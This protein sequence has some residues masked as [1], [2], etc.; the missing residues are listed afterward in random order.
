MKVPE[1]FLNFQL[2]W[3]QYSSVFLL[4]S[5]HPLSVTDIQE[6]NCHQLSEIRQAWLRFSEENSL[7]VPKSNAVMMTI[8]SAI[9][10]YLLD[11]V[12]NFQ[13]DAS[14]ETTPETKTTDSD[15]VY[16]CFGGAAISDM[17][18]L[19]YNQIKAC[20]DDQRDLLSQET[21]ILRAVNSKDKTNIPDY[22]KYRDQGYMYFPD[23]VF[24]CFLRD[25]DSAVKEIVN[26]NGL[27]QEG[28]N[29]IKVSM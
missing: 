17:L 9:Y 22:L 3:H 10:Y 26:L 19:Q 14:K 20:R 16:Y 21:S 12:E 13:S 4:S 7:P 27:Q 5:Q 8:S 24:I 6:P 11:H 28:D 2:R 1:S 25:L 23:V 29:L 15:D 18:H